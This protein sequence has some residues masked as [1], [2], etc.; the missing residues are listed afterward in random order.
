MLCVVHVPPDSVA[1]VPFVPI[2][3]TGAG[4]G[5]PPQIPSMESASDTYAFVHCVPL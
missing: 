5:P 1:N 2:E 3:Y 4:C